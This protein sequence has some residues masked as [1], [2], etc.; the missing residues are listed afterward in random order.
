M[1]LVA[2]RPTRL[3]VARVP[4]PPD[5]FQACRVPGRARLAGCCWMRP[6]AWVRPGGPM[7]RSRWHL[8]APVVEHG[9]GVDERRTGEDRA[10][11]A[12]HER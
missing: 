2:P 3:G 9:L 6:S 8:V 1:I 12:E 5:T 7:A 11:G 10:S 4:A